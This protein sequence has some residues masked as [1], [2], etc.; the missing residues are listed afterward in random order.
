M[1]IDSYAKKEIRNSTTTEKTVI[2]ED[3]M[4]KRNV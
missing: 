1:L 4:R 3:T 2:L